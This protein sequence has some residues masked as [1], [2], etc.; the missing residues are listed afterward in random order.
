[1][2][3]STFLAVAASTNLASAGFA[4]YKLIAEGQDNSGELAY[5]E[6]DR[7]NTLFLYIQLLA[8]GDHQSVIN[9]FKTLAQNYGSHG[10]SVIPRVRYGNPDGSEAPEPEDANLILQD[11]QL[12]S[13]IFADI[14][15]TIEIPVIQ[16]GFL[17]LWGEWHV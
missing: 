6:L 1:M 3:V 10:V 9:D 11:V 12:W 2:R 4:T 7:S 13:D 15:G 14:A 17:G 5:W 16:A 8:G